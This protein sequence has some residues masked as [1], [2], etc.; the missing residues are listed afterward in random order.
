MCQKELSGGKCCCNCRFHKED[1]NNKINPPYAC[2]TKHFA[3]NGW[4]CVYPM[5]VISRD[6][7]WHPTY[8]DLGWSIDHDCAGHALKLC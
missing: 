2:V 4:I 3:G 8:A 6:G 5:F 1:V 7:K